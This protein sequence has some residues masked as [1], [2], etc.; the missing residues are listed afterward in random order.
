M[1][2]AQFPNKASS[3]S[4]W[5]RLV[6]WGSH[7]Q[8]QPILA[9]FVQIIRRMPVSLSFDDGFCVVSICPL[10]SG[11]GPSSSHKEQQT[12]VRWSWV[13]RIPSEHNAPCYWGGGA[14]LP[15]L[16]LRMYP[17]SKFLLVSTSPNSWPATSLFLSIRLCPLVWMLG[18]CKAR[19]NLC[20][21]ERCNDQYGS[22]FSSLII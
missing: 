8:I 13:G 10:A 21:L 4:R 5:G 19:I 16:H 18:M 11:Q 22:C 2:I 20:L 1:E 12:A 7:E 9:L 3:L 14:P 15:M 6:L 17:V